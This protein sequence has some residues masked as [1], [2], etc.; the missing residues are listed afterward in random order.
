MYRLTKIMCGVKTQHEYVDERTARSV[1]EAI[2][3]SCD[4]ATLEKVEIQ[5]SVGRVSKRDPRLEQYYANELK[6]WRDAVIA[7]DQ[8]AVEKSEKSLM[9][10]QRQ[11]LACGCYETLTA[12][13][14]CIK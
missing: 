6:R 7:R 1:Y 12:Q 11:A 9:K 14:R 5:R 10:L 8:K 4:V 3:R 13:R 2:K